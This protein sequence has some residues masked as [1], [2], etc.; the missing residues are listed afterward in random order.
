MAIV[1]CVASVGSGAITFSDGAFDNSDWTASVVYQ[2]GPPVSFSALQVSTNGNPAQYRSVDHTYGGNGS[3]VVGHL[4]DSATFDPG[5]QGAISSIFFSYDAIGFNFGGSG[6][7]AFGGL[8]LQDGFS[9]VFGGSSSE[10]TIFHPTFGGPPVG[11]WESKSLTDLLASDFANISGAGPTEPD[12]SITATTLQLGFFSSN[13]TSGGSQSSTSS[14][15]DNWS[16]SIQPVP[17]ASTYAALIGI[18]SLVL[19]YFKR[20]KI[21]M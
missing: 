9:F 19:V 16:V 21:Q 7:V 13:G 11:T 3:L 15:I 12:F 2:D 1:V 5:T 20:R 8:I 10:G 17:E 6:A 18:A 4:L 14:G